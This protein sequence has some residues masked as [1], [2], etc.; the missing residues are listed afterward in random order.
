MDR[1]RRSHAAGRAGCGWIVLMKDGKVRYR[2]AELQALT[3]H[4]VRAFCLTN[5]NLRGAEQADRFVR[6][7]PRIY[8]AARRPGPYLYGVYAQELRLLWRRM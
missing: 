6:N 1:R 8:R 2:P 3:D 4:G 7:L 5:A